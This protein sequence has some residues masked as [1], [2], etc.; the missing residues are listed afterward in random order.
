M[1]SIENDE[2]KNYTVYKHTS[3]S[4]KV[5]IGIT[6]CPVEKRWGKNGSKY[7]TQPFYDSIN[8]IPIPVDKKKKVYLQKVKEVINN[9]RKTAYGYIWRHRDEVDSL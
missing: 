1:V 3:P 2:V 6:C 5:Y 9:K 4:G 8:D 7:K